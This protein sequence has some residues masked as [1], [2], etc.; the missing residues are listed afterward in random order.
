MHTHRYGY[1]WPELCR[2]I[3]AVTWY[4]CLKRISRHL[5][6]E[7]LAPKRKALIEHGINGFLLD[8]VEETVTA[9]DRVETLDR[10]HVRETIV[11]RF[12][13]ERMAD[14]YLQLYARIGSGG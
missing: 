2:P 11:Q 5:Y 9:I 4:P 8:S 14:A 7:A 1:L 12:S 13:V 10:A 6:G 3:A